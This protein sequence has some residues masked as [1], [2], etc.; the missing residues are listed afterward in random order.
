[1]IL[2]AVLGM[3]V[4]VATTTALARVVQ[5]DAAQG[6]LISD[7]LSESPIRTRRGRRAT[8]TQ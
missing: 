1:M 4:L 3:L 8:T 2:S 7:D 6:W 5:I